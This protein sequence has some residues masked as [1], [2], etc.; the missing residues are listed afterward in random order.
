[1]YHNL[2]A[3]T[4]PQYHFILPKLLSPSL[5]ITEQIEHKS[6]AYLHLLETFHFD[7][8][9]DDDIEFE[10]RGWKL[11]KSTEAGD[12]EGTVILLA[13]EE[14]KAGMLWLQTPQ[15]VVSPPLRTQS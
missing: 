4:F 9:Q 8:Q 15:E 13:A 14:L 6:A 5:S 11:R 10:N 1:M 7:S 12:V 3:S 2:L